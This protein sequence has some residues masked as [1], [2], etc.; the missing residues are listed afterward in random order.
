VRRYSP[1]ISPS[2]RTPSAVVRRYSSDDSRP[3][4]I[5]AASSATSSL[6]VL[7]FDHEVQDVSGEIDEFDLYDVCEADEIYVTAGGK[8]LEDENGSLRERVLTKRI[9]IPSRSPPT[10]GMS[11]AMMSTPPSV[12]SRR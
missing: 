1:T 9:F 4:R 7:D 2:S 11:G 3:R 12:S 8:G 6:T 5:A 10:F